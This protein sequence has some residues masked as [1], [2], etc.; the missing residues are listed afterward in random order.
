[1]LKFVVGGLFVTA[2]ETAEAEP[3]LFEF[4]PETICIQ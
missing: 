1:M 4:E 2:F 3:K